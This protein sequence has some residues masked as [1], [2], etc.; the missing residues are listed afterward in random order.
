M[1]TKTNHISGQKGATAVYVALSLFALVGFSA[2]AIDLAHLFVARNELQNAADA[3]ALAG[4]N[5]LI[6]RD[7]GTPIGTVNPGANSVAREIAMANTSE[8][9]NVEVNWASG[10][11]G[12][13]QRGHWAF[14]NRTFTE[15]PSLDAAD[16]NNSTFDQ[17]DRDLNFVNAVQV[18]ARRQAFPVAS[19]FA[20]IFGF[21]SF[22]MSADA[23]AYVGFS[24]G[25]INADELDQPI[26]ICRQ[27]VTESDGSFTCY[28]GRMINSGANT[29][30]QTGGWTNFSQPCTTANASSV[31][32]LVCV[33]NTTSV[34]TGYE[35]GTVG[36]MEQN[37]FNS[38][39]RCW[40]EARVDLNG[41]GTLD[42][43]IDTNGDGIPDQ[44]WRQT[45]ALIDCPG[46]NVGPCSDLLG[47]VEVEIV[48]ISGNDKNQMNEVPRRMENWSC[49]S[50]STGQQ[51][52]D[53][54]V[55]R[56]NLLDVSGTPA[57]YE[58]KVIYFK[59]VCNANI[60]VGGT[61]PTVSNTRPRTVV[62]VR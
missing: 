42:S 4:A 33:G 34:N 46:N 37:V 43:P 16:V 29:G 36:G 52:W 30:H 10:N 60:P 19:F 21:N 25:Q 38:V 13:V 27:A 41:D 55:S 18:V 3:G 51:C 35:M 50:T 8:Q 49:P 54:F 47:T 14:H 23:V 44:P 28:R 32:P 48:W 53:S 40:K 58:N 31:R 1:K 9:T 11:T 5:V 24:G 15:N 2:L 61:G 17:L 26:A 7:P 22:Q 57:T 20:R 56:F 12:D 39:E 6:F 62:L 45:M 59:P